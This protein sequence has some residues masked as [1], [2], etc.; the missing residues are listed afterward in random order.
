MGCPP[1][2]DLPNPGIKFKS[3]VPAI[4]QA[5]SL[6]LELS[7]KIKLLAISIEHTPLSVVIIMKYKYAC[8]KK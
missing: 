1:P 8:L 5:D 7:G 2:M 4:L 3:P 6:P